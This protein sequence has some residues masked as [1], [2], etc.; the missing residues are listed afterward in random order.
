MWDSMI[1][2]MKNAIYKQK[3]NRLD[4]SSSFLDVIYKIHFDCWTKN[5]TPHCLA[6]SLYSITNLTRIINY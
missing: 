2:N 1:E 5:N 6:Y 4:K 3:R